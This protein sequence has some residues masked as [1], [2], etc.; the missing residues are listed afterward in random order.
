[1]VD[2]MHEFERVGWVVGACMGGYF[3]GAWVSDGWE[4]GHLGG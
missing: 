1:M 4:M 2:W 3:V